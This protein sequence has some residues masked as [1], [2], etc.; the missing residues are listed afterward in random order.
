M[1]KL[2]AI[3]RLLFHSETCLAMFTRERFRPII[4][5]CTNQDSFLQ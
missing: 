1:N 4:A 2:V 5:H 3:A